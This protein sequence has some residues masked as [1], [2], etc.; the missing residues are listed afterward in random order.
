MS[1]DYKGFSGNNLLENTAYSVL[2]PR[3]QEPVKLV[4]LS[5]LHGKEFGENNKRLLDA[6]GNAKP[7]MICFTGDL[8]DKRRKQLQPGIELMEKLPE[9]APVYYIPGNHEPT[10]GRSKELFSALRQNGVHVLLGQQKNVTIAGNKI[11]ILGLYEKE[12][13]EEAVEAALGQLTGFSGF[14]MVLCHFPQNIKQYRKYSFDLML[15]GHAHGGQWRV[16][17]IGGLYAPGQGLLPR[18]TAG[19]CIE[20]EGSLI[21]SRGLGNSLFPFR[22]GN[23]PEVIIVFLLPME[24]RKAESGE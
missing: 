7:D 24:K 18:Y 23:R 17:G 21:I 13:T 20:G 9:I 3:L 5:D 22:L 6:V 16:P 4:H 10:S 2:S 8:I 15:S 1:K 14:R 11:A 12:M 19:C